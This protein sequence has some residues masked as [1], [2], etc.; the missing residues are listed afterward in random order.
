[1][2][3]DAFRELGHRLVDWV[4]DY[5]KRM[6]KLPVMSPVVPGEV[7]AAF[8]RSAPETPQS[9]QALLELLDQAVVP[10]ITHWN[11]SRFFA[12]FPGNSAFPSV[13]ADLVCSALG[14]QAM[15]W[16]TSPAATEVEEVVMEWLQDLVGLPRTFTG[17]IQDTASTA[18]LVALLCARERTTGF[19]QR[20]GGMQAEPSALTVYYSEEAHSSVEKGALMAGFGAENLRRIETDEVFALRPERLAHA[21]ETDLGQGK[22]PCAIVAGIGTTA[23]TAFDPLHAMLALAKKYGLWLHVDAAMAGSAM[24]LPECRPR[25]QGVEEAD[26]VVFNP[27]KWL[28]VGLDLSAYYVRDVAHLTQTLSTQPSYLKTAQD[29]QVKNFRDWGVP[30]GRRFRALK[31]WFLLHLE[32]A[33]AVRRRLRRDLENARWLAAEIARNPDWEVIA[34][35]ALQTVCIRH[36]S[37]D[38]MAVA[39][40]VN[41]A[42]RAYV[43]PSVVRGR[44]MIRVS[45]GSEHSER[46]DVQA[47]WDELQRAAACTQRPT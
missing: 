46:P 2:T 22:R 8:P 23:T 30:L 17:V 15:S 42:G 45:I 25:W 12:Y 33:E 44:A 28:G 41:L 6:D 13:L 10:G 38:N 14:A 11:H 27:H 39:Q 7:K 3:P 34:P 35:V 18:T 37:A 40:R 24:I 29:G 19:G 47:V 5:R 32:G 43:T 26:S 4:A 36:R 31:L 20:R 9:P 21:I 16:Q 1:M